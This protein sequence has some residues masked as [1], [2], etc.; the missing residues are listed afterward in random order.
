MRPGQF[1]L[2]CHT[3]SSAS[4]GSSDSHRPSLP[5]PCGIFRRHNTLLHTLH[6][7]FPYHCANNVY[8][9]KP[10]GPWWPC[11]A[12]HRMCNSP[13]AWSASLGPPLLAFLASPCLV[14]PRLAA[15]QPYNSGHRCHTIKA[16]HAIDTMRTC[17]QHGRDTIAGHASSSDLSPQVG[18]P[19]HRLL[20]SM[21]MPPPQR[22]DIALPV[23]GL[24]LAS[25]PMHAC[26]APLL[27]LPG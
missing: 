15:I 16:M 9:H 2:S 10:Q 4:R 7:P 24:S 11:F 18:T 13:H 26:G 6:I 23:R 22:H 3:N 25:A 12:V 14:V 27:P 1:Q 17:T 21:H 20:A 8:P 19:S 5:A